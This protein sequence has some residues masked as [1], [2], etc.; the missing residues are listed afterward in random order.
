MS[1]L[2]E[3]LNEEVRKYNIKTGLIDQLA[4]FAYQKIKAVCLEQAK[5]GRTNATVE[6]QFTGSCGGNEQYFPLVRSSVRD[7]LEKEGL[8]TA[9][10]WQESGRF[11]VVKW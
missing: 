5:E 6:I 3:I 2:K 7:K 10:G 8:Y 1:N 4:D 11:I 9:T